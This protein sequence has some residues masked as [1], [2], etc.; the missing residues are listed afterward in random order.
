M[1]TLSLTLVLLLAYFASIVFARVTGLSV[2]VGFLLAGISL[3][4]VLLDSSNL[5]ENIRL[6]AEI[7]VA[8]LLFEVG[9][10]LPLKKLIASWRQ[11]FISGPAQMFCT[12]AIIYCSLLALGV[13]D[14]EAQILAFALSLSSTA[15]V[16]QIFKEHA[17]LDLLQAKGLFPF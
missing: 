16:L 3:G 12:A 1:D 15:V 9:S 11:F 14:T 5:Q 7:G 4:L 17:K 10:H 8:F 2:I 6:L 13:N